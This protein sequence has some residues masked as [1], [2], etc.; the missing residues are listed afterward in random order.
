MHHNL[1]LSIIYTDRDQRRVSLCK[2]IFPRQVDLPQ[3][4]RLISNVLAATAPPPAAAPL[5]SALLLQK[6]FSF[7][8]STAW[9]GRQA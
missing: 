4:V 7:E 1:A 5:A 8:R 3:K 9:A 2:T 6:Q